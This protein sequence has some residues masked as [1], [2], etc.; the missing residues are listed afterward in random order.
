[1]LAQT[2]NPAPTDG[3]ALILA[4][5]SKS[6]VGID[7]MSDKPPDIHIHPYCNRRKVVAD[8]LRGEK[9]ID[10]APNRNYAKISERLLSLIWGRGEYEWRV[11]M[12]FEGGGV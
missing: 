9:S 3:D 8:D 5:P 7:V 11:C 4:R 6:A 12:A 10:F 1:M 2:A